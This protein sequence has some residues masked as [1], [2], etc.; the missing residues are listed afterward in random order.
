MDN[1]EIDYEV[2]K[3]NRKSISIE[4]TKEC[5]VY[6]R[7]PYY[8][9][10]E[11]IEMFVKSKTKWIKTKQK[12]LETIIKAKK[13][14]NIEK[15]SNE[16]IISI[17]NKAKEIIPKKVEKYAKQIG[18]TY[19]NI[20]IKKQKTCWGS[21]SKKGNLN[22]N[23]LLMLMPDNVVDY[24]VVHEL[25]HRKEMNHANTFWNEVG[26]IIPDYKLH[27]EWLKNNGWSVM[28]KMYN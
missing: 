24:V 25:C 5:K 7:A 23:C 19:G 1:K 4:I 9:S 3:S 13:A 18:V 16:Q 22:F 21:C 11:H 2:I 12:E 27:R 17:T 26:K 14:Q 15:L 28:D 20:K 10:K 8:L 6:V